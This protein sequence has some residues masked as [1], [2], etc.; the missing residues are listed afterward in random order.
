[1][2]IIVTMTISSAI[3]DMSGVVNVQSRQDGDYMSVSMNRCSGCEHYDGFNS[4]NMVR[5]SIGVKASISSGC[6]SFKP[7]DTANCHECCFNQNGM[8][9][10]DITCSKYGKINGQRSRCEGYAERWG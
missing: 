3:V 4:S 9:S 1:V 6:S 2:V 8:K 5:C 7:D 10:F